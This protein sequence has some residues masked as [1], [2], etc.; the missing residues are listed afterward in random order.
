MTTTADANL[1]VRADN[2]LRMRATTMT[3]PSR[4][5]ETRP[6]PRRTDIVQA[7]PRPITSVAIVFAGQIG[8]SSATTPRPVIRAGRVQLLP[9]PSTLPFSRSSARSVTNQR[10]SSPSG[11]WSSSLRAAC[12]GATPT[13]SL[14]CSQE[15]R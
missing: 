13:K 2:L 5:P 7:T 9:N 4:Y 10:S 1:S 12:C 3:G 8:P 6:Q 14:H 15:R 11:S